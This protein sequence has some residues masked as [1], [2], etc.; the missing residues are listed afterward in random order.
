MN[1]S[2]ISQHAD[3]PIVAKIVECFDHEKFQEV[4]NL[5]EICLTC[6]NTRPHRSKHCKYTDKCI[7]EYDHYCFFLTKPIG[8]GNRKVFFCGLL[9][10]Y[11]ATAI[12]LYLN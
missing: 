6:Q 12:F 7:E 4:P 3:T 10:N 9:I 1:C 11:L 2:I 8:K 5:E